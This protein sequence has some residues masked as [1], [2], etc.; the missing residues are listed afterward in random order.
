MCRQWQCPAAQL[1]D[2]MRHRFAGR[3]F[4]ARN[5]NVSASL[6]KAKDHCPA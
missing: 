2:L 5:H 6:R 4:A 3:Q 1:L